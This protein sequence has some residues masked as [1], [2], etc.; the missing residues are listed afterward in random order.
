MIVTVRPVR[1]DFASTFESVYGGQW[2]MVPE[3]ETLKKTSELTAAISHTKPP[4]Y[5]DVSIRV[6]LPLPFFKWLIDNVKG[7]PQRNKGIRIYSTSG[8][9]RNLSPISS[10]NKE[11]RWDYA[12]QHA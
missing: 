8:C 7:I 10:R 6:Q 9:H 1:V 5:L 11:P 2:A 3:I 12:V 4:N